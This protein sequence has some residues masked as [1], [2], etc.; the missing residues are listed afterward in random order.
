MKRKLWEGAM[1]LRKDYMTEVSINE[2]MNVNNRNHKKYRYLAKTTGS[3]IS[4]SITYILFLT[5]MQKGKPCQ[6]DLP[7]WKTISQQFR[8]S[9][10]YMSSYLHILHYHLIAANTGT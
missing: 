2:K 6:M 4:N 3:S 5:K 1:Y 10:I 7:S 8:T 9:D